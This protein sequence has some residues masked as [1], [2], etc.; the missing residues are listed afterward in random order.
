MKRISDPETLNSL[1]ARLR[2]L[3]PDSPRRWGTLSAGEMLCHLGDAHES[4]L[5][6]RVPPGPPPS[7]VSRPIYKWLALYAPVA[8]PRGVKTRPGVD[9]RIDG[10]RPSDFERDRER[11]IATLTAIT[12]AAPANLSPVHFKF[13]PMKA[14]DWYVWAYRHVD[15]HLRQFGL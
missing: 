6:T 14:R 9:P 1:V 13:G 12:K 4:V 5:R 11:T 2:Q 8:W 7:A 10:T 15:H 3:R